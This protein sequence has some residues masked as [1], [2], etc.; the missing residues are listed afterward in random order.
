MSYRGGV[1]QA[2]SASTDIQAQR[3]STVTAGTL[4][5]IGMAVA[6]VGGYLMGRKGSPSR[7]NG[8]RR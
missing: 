1:G 8:R 5:L 4:G 2:T 3:A 7:R 6:F